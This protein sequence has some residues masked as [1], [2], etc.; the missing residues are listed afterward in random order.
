[1]P[2]RSR[3]S[4]TG[5]TSLKPRSRSV[6][7]VGR[8][9]EHGAV[10]GQQRD[11]GVVEV[12]LVQ[13]GDE[14]DLGARGDRLGRLGQLDERVAAVVRRAL[15]R[16]AGLGRIEHRVDQQAP[17]GVV[18]LERGVADQAESHRGTVTG[19]SAR[20]RALVD[21]P[22]GRRGVGPRPATGE[23]AP[24]AA[25]RGPRPACRRRR[26]GRR[27]SRGRRAPRAAT[28]RRPR[29]PASRTRAPPP[30]GARSPPPPT[31]ARARGRRCRARRARRRRPRRSRSRRRRSS[32][33]HGPAAPTSRDFFLFKGI[34]NCSSLGC[35]AASDTI[36]SFLNGS[37]LKK[38]TKRLSSI[39]IQCVQ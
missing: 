1:M 11:R 31:A 4:S 20:Q 14:H 29:R 28:G 36:V 9:G 30:P 2:S 18:E 19:S 37:L 34:V 17:P 6:S 27:T 33:A 7:D 35:P 21:G 25:R 32:R 10:A 5:R 12:V 22:G 26:R 39:R 3:A 13:V 8:L 23:R 24:G 38:M 15:D 16:A